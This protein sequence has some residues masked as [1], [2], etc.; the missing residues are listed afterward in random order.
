MRR[1]IPATQGQAWLAF[2]VTSKS[3]AVPSCLV[4]PALGGL[5]VAQAR[6]PTASTYILR[7][8]NL[9]VAMALGQALHTPR[10]AQFLHDQLTDV[11]TLSQRLLE[12][13]EGLDRGVQDTR[14]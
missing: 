2:K 1:C 4:T 11:A 3:F 5:I 7:T 13:L 6:R 12:H 9:H 10:S 8:D 14:G